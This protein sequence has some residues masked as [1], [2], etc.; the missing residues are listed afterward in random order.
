MGSPLGPT[1]ANYYMCNLENAILSDDATRP[2]F[3]ARYVDDI[4]LIVNN[5]QELEDLRIA[6]QC[7]SVLKFTF[8][9]ETNKKIPFL[10]VLISRKNSSL[11]TS[12]YT[13]ETNYGDCLNFNSICPDKYKAGVIRAFLHRGYHVSS[14]WQTFHEEIDRIKQIL[15]NNNYPMNFIEENVKKFLE[16]K[17]SHREA[18]NDTDNKINLYYCNQMT[19]SYKME[20]KRLR[21][22]VEDN[23][24][25]AHD[26]DQLS[27]IIFYRNKKLRNLL[28]SNKPKS[29]SGNISDR[30]H[31][32]YQYTCNIDG[33][34]AG[35]NFYIG[36]TACSVW[37][38]FRMHT[39]NGSIVK[40]LA[41]HH[42]VHKPPR[43]QL[44]D[45]VTILRSAN[46]KRDLIYLEAV[47]IKESK[48][49]LNSQNEGCDRLLKIFVH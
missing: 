48:P 47:L 38:R 20:E 37:E 32:V 35:Q 21:K 36:Y 15:T 17:F 26:R 3:Y 25:P 9:L 31:V 30:H 19:S 6:F 5:Y 8:E 44:V 46:D 10:D 14:D 39:Q 27:L 18:G 34:N 41:E 33:C 11:H 13:K 28:I 29:T 42:A 7:N 16:S 12:V 45:N 22:I 24:T 43:K 40:H 23:I 2:Q 4:C 1:F 49:P